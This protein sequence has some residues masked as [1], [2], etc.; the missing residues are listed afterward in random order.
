MKLAVENNPKV[1]YNTLYIITYLFH[2]KAST[3]MIYKNKAAYQN[4]V[5][6]VTAIISFQKTN[7]CHDMATQCNKIKDRMIFVTSKHNLMFN[8]NISIRNV[9]AIIYKQY[10]SKLYREDISKGFLKAR[11]SLRLI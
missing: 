1:V 9:H 7:L 8:I 4:N 3:C 10:Y 2:Y 11:S 6:L 5:Y